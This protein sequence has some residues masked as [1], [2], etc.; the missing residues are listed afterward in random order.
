MRSRRFLG[1]AA[2]AAVLILSGCRLTANV[3]I[4]MNADGSGVVAVDL[5]AD[6][7]L[8]AKA[9]AAVSDLRLDDARQA[10][11]EVTGPAPTPDGGS[12]IRLAKPFHSAEEATA[13]VAEINGPQGP[14]R[15]MLVARAVTFARVDITVS[16]AVQWEG[17]LAAFSDSALTAALGRTPLEQE[18]AA[19]GVAPEDALALTVTVKLPGEVSGNGRTGD[20]GAMTWTPVL[21]GSG[22]TEISAQSSLVDRGAQSARRTEHL[23]RGAVAVYVGIVVLGLVV[24]SLVILRRRSPVSPRRTPSP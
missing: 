24:L 10:G 13:I 7:D 23:A 5:V 18:V 19:S 12:S 20:D 9:P 16:G 1:L 3:T 4:T 2:L 22:R 6:A 21:H 17:G 15:D 14:L 11:W 8:L